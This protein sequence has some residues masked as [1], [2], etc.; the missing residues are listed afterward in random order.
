MLDFDSVLDGAR[1][2]SAD[3]QLRLIDALWDMVP[4]EATLPLHEDW[5]LELERRV[6]AI[7]AGSSRT[8]PWTTI[9]DEALARLGHGKPS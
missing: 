4:A 5:A 3:E 6:A 8:L 2:L 1:Q 9:R 7:R